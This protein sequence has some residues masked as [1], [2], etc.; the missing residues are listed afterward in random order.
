M[1][2]QAKLSISQMAQGGSTSLL[3]PII[4]PTRCRLRR[5]TWDASSMAHCPARGLPPDYAPGAPAS[6]GTMRSSPVI[7]LL[8]SPLGA[9]QTVVSPTCSAAWPKV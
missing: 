8:C 4:T 7:H 9:H 1:P 3:Y 2:C 6:P 5:G